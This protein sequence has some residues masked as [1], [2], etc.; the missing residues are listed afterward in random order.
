MKTGR[1]KEKGGR[2]NGQRNDSDDGEERGIGRERTRDG[3]MAGGE[4]EEDD[5]H[6]KRGKQT[7]LRGRLPEELTLTPLLQDTSEQSERTH[8]FRFS[9]REPS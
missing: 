2:K 1:G 9:V 3:K 6:G 8:S 4:D 7:L 5:A